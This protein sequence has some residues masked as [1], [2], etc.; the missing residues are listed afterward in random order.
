MDKNFDIT[1]ENLLNDI[2]EKLKIV[3]YSN[4]KYDTFKKYLNVE[5]RYF[6]LVISTYKLFKKL[7]G[8]KS[9]QEFLK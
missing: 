1:S 3:T 7:L 6:S 4:F 9:L 8:I 5:K 2:A